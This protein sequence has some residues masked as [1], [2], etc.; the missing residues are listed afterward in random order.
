MGTVVT[1]R[2][3][4]LSQTKKETQIFSNK[5]KITSK[6]ISSGSGA[7]RKNL[8][9]YFIRTFFFSESKHQGEVGGLGVFLKQKLQ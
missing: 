7:R 9:K 3:E 1:F 4:H 2:S 5:L 6:D 8:Q